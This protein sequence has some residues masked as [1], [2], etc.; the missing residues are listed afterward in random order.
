[1]KAK[2]DALQVVKRGK[3]EFIRTSFPELVAGHAIVQPKYL[4]LC[5]SDVRM[6]SYA[7]EAVYPFPHGTT[8]HEIIA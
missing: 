6:L 7:P 8:G 4:T 5:G 1:M 2:M 3:A